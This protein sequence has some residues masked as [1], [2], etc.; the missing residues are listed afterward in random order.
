MSAGCAL[1]P[2]D[3]YSTKMAS[4][5][6]SGEHPPPVQTL[7][8]AVLGSV[9]TVRG[10]QKHPRRVEVRGRRAVSVSGGGVGGQK[11]CASNRL[12]FV[13]QQRWS[14]RRCLEKSTGVRGRLGGISDSEQL[15][16]R[17]KYAFLPS[18]APP[19]LPL[20]PINL[21][22]PRSSQSPVNKSQQ[23]QS[24][25]FIPSACSVGSGLFHR[26]PVFGK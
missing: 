24:A 20:Q 17:Q 23:N 5:G 18:S 25:C 19:N 12:R 16:R 26:L 15:W 4:E 7:A 10:F 6:A 3:R 11:R 1:T 9:D 2:A 8:T 13:E 14:A 22:D 21:P